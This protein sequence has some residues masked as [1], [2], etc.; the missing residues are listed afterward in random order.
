MKYL[1]IFLW[2]VIKFILKPFF[3]LTVNLIVLIIFGV[4]RLLVLLW[5]LIWHGKLPRIKPLYMLDQPYGV[6]EWAANVKKNVEDT[7]F[8]IL[9]KDFIFDLDFYY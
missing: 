8:T 7:D 1:F 5:D 3:Y 2:T 9:W 6:K 4:V